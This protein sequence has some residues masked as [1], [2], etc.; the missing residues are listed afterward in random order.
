M[1]HASRED[2]RPDRIRA[3]HAVGVDVGGTGTSAV[4]LGPDQV[5]L[6]RAEAD[7]PAA[8][9]AS[10][11][12]G[13]I[14]DLV[15]HVDPDAQ[16]DVLGVGATGGVDAR[17]GRV[18]AATSAMPGWAGTL[19]PARLRECLGERHWRHVGA[20]NDVHAFVLAE[21]ALGSAAGEVDVL[22][23]MVG[24]GVGGGVL[25][26][27]RLV[28]GRRGVA[29]HLGH[30]PVS[31]ASGRACPCGALGHVEAV[32]AAPA[33][34]ADYR[35][36]A[37]P[38]DG[39]VADLEEVSR[40]AGGGDRIAREVLARGG[41]CLGEALAGVVAVCDPAV[42]VVGGGV[43]DAGA[44]FLDPLREA[45]RVHAHP[46]VADVAVRRAAPGGDAVA[47]GAA[48]HALDGAP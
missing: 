41:S 15:R 32:S 4:L 38:A 47:V 28:L 6:A 18:V 37:G 26:D 35:R 1:S 10:A 11:V 12:V 5:V 48:L 34:L 44:I 9:G 2:T 25:A 16:A 24:T 3:C 23:V 40:R 42:V 14:G 43:L 33:M 19:L 46:V 39:V 13:V 8:A 29:G 20:V 21:A 7:T 27:G 22:G 36:E 30:V 31:G 17:D 45:L